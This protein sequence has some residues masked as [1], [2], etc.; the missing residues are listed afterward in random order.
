MKQS[1]KAD[2]LFLFFSAASAAA[3]A[4]SPKEKTA[5]DNKKKKEEKQ[6]K[7]FI[8]FSQGRHSGGPRASADLFRRIIYSSVPLAQAVTI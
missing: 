6:L 2:M 7:R 5:E 1:C 4:T 8:L 3:A